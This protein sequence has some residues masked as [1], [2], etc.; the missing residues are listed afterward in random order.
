MLKNKGFRLLSKKELLESFFTFCRLYIS[1]PSTTDYSEILGTCSYKGKND[2]V[3]KGYWWLG[4]VDENTNMVSC[5]NYKGKIENANPTCSICGIRPIIDYSL[6]EPYRDYESVYPEYKFIDFGE[7]PSSA[8]SERIAVELEKRYLNGEL[9]KSS[10][11]YTYLDFDGS[12]YS[13]KKNCAYVFFGDK[14]VRCIPTH[15]S[16]GF[17]HDGRKIYQESPYWLKVSPVNWIVDTAS[18]IAIPIS[19]ILGGIP[20]S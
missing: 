17:L 15:N 1:S 7:Y 6:I 5:V 12:T 13:V 9:D 19:I 8:V 16:V 18:N 4:D 10:D 2:S 11:S 14:Y 3:R 20:F